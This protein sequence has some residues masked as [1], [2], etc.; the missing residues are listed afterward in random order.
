M[1]RIPL[2]MAGDQP[3]AIRRFIDRRGDLNLF[4]M[5]ANAPSVFTGWIQM[6]DEMADSSTFTPRMRE[7]IILRVAH[8]QRSPYELNQHI[9][10]A[11]AA[12]LTEVQIAAVTGDLGTAEF[13]PD[14][15]I[16]LD[17][18][19]ELCSTHRLRDSTF[20]A[21]RGA[22][23]DAAT[24]ELLMIISCYYGLALVLNAVDVE[25]DTTARFH[26]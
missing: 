21:V 25:V 12:G 15:R 3:E 24:V 4:R 11:R 10:L 9:G 5:L 26:M 20:E 16:V 17:S 18:V 14:E 8:L 7:L 19:T 23:G 22:L 6:V 2:T 1:S 13:G